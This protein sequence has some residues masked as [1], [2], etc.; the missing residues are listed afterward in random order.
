VNPLDALSLAVDFLV[1]LLGDRFVPLFGL[2]ETSFVL[3]ER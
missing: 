1:A 2:M 3:A